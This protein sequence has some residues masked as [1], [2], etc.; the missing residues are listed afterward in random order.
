M[1]KLFFENFF[2]EYPLEI[3]KKEKNKIWVREKYHWLTVLTTDEE[4]QKAHKKRII[5]LK[6]DVGSRF[7]DEDELWVIPFLILS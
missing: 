2:S 7:Q 1:S 5:I 4:W 6:P 3:Y